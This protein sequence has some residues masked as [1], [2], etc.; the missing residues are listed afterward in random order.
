MKKLLFSFLIAVVLFSSFAIYF[1][2]SS[3]AADWGPVWYDTSIL[4]YPSWYL[5]VYDDSSTPPTEVFGERYTAAQVQWVVFSIISGTLNAIIGRGPWVCVMK[6]VGVGDVGGV[7]TCVDVL[8]D[9]IGI[10]QKEEET[11][12]SWSGFFAS[13]PIS[14]IGYLINKAH[15]FHLVPQTYAQGFGYDIGGNIVLEVWAK[16]R[17]IA[18][19]LLV[20]IVIILSFMIM[21]RLK[22]NPQTVLTIQTALPKIIIAIILITFSYALAGLLIDVMYIAIGLLSLILSSDGGNLSGMTATELFKAFELSPIFGRSI[23]YVIKMFGATLAGIW[24]QVSS[25]VDGATGIAAVFGIILFFHVFIK[26]LGIVIMVYKTY[27]MIIISIITAP[28]EFLIGALSGGGLS[29]WVKKMV[30][31]LSLYPLL[32]VMFFFSFF[33]LYQAGGPDTTGNGGYRPRLIASEKSIWKPPFTHS[34][35]TGGGF[36]WIMISYA[37]FVSIPKAAEIAQGMITKRMP[38]LGSAIG[39]ATGSVGKGITTGAGIL[40]TI[41]GGLGDIQH[42]QIWQKA[43]KEAA[44]A[45]KA[46]QLEKVKS[47]TLSNQNK[48]VT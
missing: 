15:N 40:K 41:G 14:G 26:Y 36:M 13:Q 1:P 33:F 22:L 48:S 29:G 21:F 9:T 23:E 6:V 45:K 47:G 20:L 17:N 16:A 28:F 43:M 38:D 30:G 19:S 37:I 5:K 25:G 27:A 3:K 35:G 7:F 32:C 12:F 34:P 4:N 10:G 11:K 18:Y 31:Y 46:A 2:R 42:I 24:S 39:E 8:L 44:D